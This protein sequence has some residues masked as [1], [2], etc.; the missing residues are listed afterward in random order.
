MLKKFR[1]KDNKYRLKTVS[2]EMQRMRLYYLLKCS[3]VK[4][5]EKQYLFSKSFVLKQTSMT[6][7]TRIRNGCVSTGRTGYVTQLVRLSRMQFKNQAS[8]GLLVGFRKAS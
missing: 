5:K 1:A 8:D 6:S 4:N 3:W 2:K 7:I